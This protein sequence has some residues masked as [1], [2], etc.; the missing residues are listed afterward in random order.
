M[1]YITLR[2]L[3]RNGLSIREIASKLGSSYTNTRYWLK[4]YGLRTKKRIE[5]KCRCGETNPNK[6]YGYKR[7]ICGRC[8]NKYVIKKGQ[9]NK[10]RMVEFLGGKC[11][12]CGYD[13]FLCSLDIHH[14]KPSKKDPSFTSARYWSWKRIKKELKHCNL[15]CR[16]C[17]AAHHAGHIGV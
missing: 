17:H 15:L 7:H 8:Q 2:S 4:K 5:Y 9:E 12:A 3:V 13:K 6:F 1:N 10:K 14:T 16:N 11:K